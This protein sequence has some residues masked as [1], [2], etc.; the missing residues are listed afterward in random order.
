MHSATREPPFKT[1]ETLCSLLPCDGWNKC[2]LNFSVSTI[3][4][5]QEEQA[6]CRCRILIDLGMIITQNGA[7]TFLVCECG[8]MRIPSYLSDVIHECVVIVY[9]VLE[10]MVDMQWLVKG[11]H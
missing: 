7:L 3:S 8:A 9:H 2:V 4:D 6:R 5:A 1:L 11:S 10:Q